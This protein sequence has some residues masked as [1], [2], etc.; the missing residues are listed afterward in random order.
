MSHAASGQARGATVCQVIARGVAVVGFLGY[1]AIFPLDH[2]WA[3]PRHRGTLAGQLFWWL[4]VATVVGAAAAGWAW[5]R[6]R[7]LG[8]VIALIVLPPLVAGYAES[9]LGWEPLVQSVDPELGPQI[10]ILF[11]P[12]VVLFALGGLW[13]RRKA[14][15]RSATQGPPGRSSTSRSAGSK[16]A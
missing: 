5:P 7:T 15:L 11:T 13:L 4:S 6:W 12:I 10:F 1:I 16:R 14:D 3:E 2:V 9:S 8:V